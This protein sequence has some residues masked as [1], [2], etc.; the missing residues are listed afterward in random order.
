MIELSLLQAA[1]PP[2]TRP[3]IVAIG[4]AYFVVIAAIGVWATRRTRTASDFFVAGRGIGLFA[5]TMAAMSATVSGFTFIGGPGFVYASGF[6]AMFLVLPAALTTT[7][8]TWILAKRLRLLGELRGLLTIP[9]AIGARYRS[10][11]AQGLAGVAILIAVIGYLATNLLALGIVV[12]AIFS[13]GLGWGIWIGMAVTLAYTAAGGMVAG[14]YT[15]LFQGTLMTVASALVFAFALDA[16]GGLA[17]MSRAIASADAM[18]LEPWGRMS[19]LAAMSLYFVFG[20]GAVAQ[21]HVAHKF[22]MLRDPRRLKWYP[23]LMT[24]VLLMAL[25]L[26]F[27]I[28]LSVRSLVSSGALEPLAKPD[29]A[30]PA[31]LLAFAPT[32]L[33]GLVFAGVAAA[34]MST[35]NSFMSIGAAAVT[36][37][38]PVALGRRLRHELAVG[39]LA[40]VGISVL[41]ATIAQVSGTLVAFLGIFGWGL[42]ASTLV[43][44][45]AIGLNWRGATRTGAIASIATG[46]L[47]TLALESVAWFGVY[48]FPTGVTISGASLATSCLVFFGVSWAGRRTAASTLDADVGLIMDI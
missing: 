30:T 39:R 48:A 40:T 23:L 9:D 44:A 31:F 18:F 27:G 10:P 24:V 42:F 19:P 8:T 35:V 3:T 47:M 36:H 11:A 20:V 43:P 28:G 45:L 46:L 6:G 5:L 41:A 25:L 34:I 33:S 29:D 7:M 16:G 37:D 21:P 4:V 14:V 22:Y 26:Y 13:T 38:V 17:A 1:L 2:L 15:D 12:D 32:I